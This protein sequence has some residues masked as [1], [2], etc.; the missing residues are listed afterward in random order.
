MFSTWVVWGK[1]MNAHPPNSTP[2]QFGPAQGSLV[3]G[4]TS[5]GAPTCT[6]FAALA[7]GGVAGVSTVNSKAPQ[8][9][10]CGLVTDLL[11]KIATQHN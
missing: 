3:S 10:T 8:V 7:S 5:Q 1:D 9:D 4:Q 2:A 6:G 11:T